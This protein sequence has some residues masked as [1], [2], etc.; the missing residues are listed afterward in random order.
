MGTSK[1]DENQTVIQKNLKPLALA[2]CIALSWS[3]SFAVD[4][5]TGGNVNLLNTLYSTSNLS[6]DLTANATNATLATFIINNNSANSFTLAITLINGG[7][8]IKAGGADGSGVLFTTCDLNP[9]G[10][11]TLGVGLTA[12]LPGSTGLRTSDLKGAVA[13]PAILTP[14]SPGAQSAA[15]SNYALQVRCSWVGRSLIEGLYTE[16]VRATLTANL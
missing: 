12:L 7:E 10:T 2:L 6:L 16:I 8:F 11:G 3:K 1:I 15:T 4:A 5:L 13:G 9:G 14:W